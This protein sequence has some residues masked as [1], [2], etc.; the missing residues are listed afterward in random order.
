[1]ALGVIQSSTQHQLDQAQAENRSVAAVLSAP[2]ARL[3]V[4][5]TTAGGVATVVASPSRHAL[6]ISTAGLPALSGGKV[7]ELWFLSGQTAAGQVCSRRRR[8]GAPPRC[9]RP[10]SPRGM[11]SP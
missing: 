3:A 2:D 10:A 5:R 7:Y 6:I 9:W 1:M 8:P 4:H 11:R